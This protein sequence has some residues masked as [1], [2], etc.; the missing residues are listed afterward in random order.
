MA[1]LANMKFWHV[2]VMDGYKIVED[3]KCL[4]VKEANDLFAEKK[5]EYPAPKYAVSKENY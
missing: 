3:I 5:K 1:S 2:V 4:S